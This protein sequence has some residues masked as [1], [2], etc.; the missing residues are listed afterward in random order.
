MFYLNDLIPHP[1]V[2][3][4]DLRHGTCVCIYVCVYVYMYVC[5][6][7]YVHTLALSL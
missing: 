3:L 5:V 1:T 7:M 6:L 4:T 2:I